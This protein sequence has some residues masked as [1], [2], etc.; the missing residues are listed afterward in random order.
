[1]WATSVVTDRFADRS[2]T[3]FGTGLLCGFGTTL[4][5]VHA[6]HF[7]TDLHESLAVL[8]VG[9]LL[10]AGVVGTVVAGTVWLWYGDF[11]RR[12][13]SHVAGWTVVGGLVLL[14][15]VGLMSWYQAWE[16]GSIAE[17]LFMFANALSGGGSLGFLVGVYDT[18][19]RTARSESAAARHRLEHRSNQLS[20]LNRVLRHDIRNHVNVIQGR[21][22][23]LDE[24]I[25]DGSEEIQRIRR[26]AD[27]ITT[28]SDQARAM[29]ELLE[30][31]PDR[32][33]QV[34][35]VASVQ[36]ALIDISERHPSVETSVSLPPSEPVLAHPLVTTAVT[37]VL[38]AT[39]QRTDGS[40][41]VIDVRIRPQPADDAEEVALLVSAEGPGIPPQEI[42]ALDRGFETPLEHGSGLAFWVIKW[43]M[44]ASGGEFRITADDADRTV[45]SL[46]FEPAD[47][48]G[49]A[50]PSR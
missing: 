28:L 14:L 5:L 31:D 30:A 38:R 39:I 18:K 25:D 41:T 4:L 43:V 29:E 16:G 3:W 23:L 49:T 21:T 15:A 37:N 47:R 40:A 22:E 50:G 6:I 12:Y 27:E 32:R 46:H 10:P 7:Y 8:V 2:N 9:C 1:M 35:L 36:T 44:S 33:E 48:V 34:D 13:I 17:P 45:F 11:P 42:T 19:Q 26:K 24:K 20:V